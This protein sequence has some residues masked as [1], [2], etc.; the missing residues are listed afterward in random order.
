MEYAVRFT[1]REQAELL[2]YEP[3]ASPLGPNELAGKTLYT[4]VS[5]GTEIMGGYLGDSFPKTPGYA[6]VFRVE[7]VGAEVTDLKPGD[8]AFCMGPHQS[9]Q[10]VVR[11]RALPVPEGVKP[12]H[13]PFARMLGVSMSTLVTTAARPPDQVLVTG[14]GLVGHLAARLFAACGYRVTGCDPSERRRAFA[15]EFGLR[16]LPSVP[17]A[18]PAYQDRVSLVVECSG[19]EQA[20]VDA[21]RLVRKRGEVILIGAPWRKRTDCSAHDLLFPI[22]FRYV[23]LR[24][25]WEWELPMEET[26]FRIGS[27]FGNYAGALNWLAEGRLNMEGVAQ[28]REPSEAQ[29]VF[30]ELMHDRCAR[31]AVTFDWTSLGA[32]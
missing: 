3:D 29:A 10:R 6:A 26:D 31:L 7:A 2:P 8:F 12:E 4:L 22:F 19:H 32:E 28:R 5:A 11:N 15:E 9:R 14:L 18:D 20:P 13:V 17:L 24:S 30:Q 1:A 27:I 16:A 23:T 21:V 25:G